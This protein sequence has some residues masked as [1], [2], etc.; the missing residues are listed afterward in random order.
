MISIIFSGGFRLGESWDECMVTAFI[1]TRETLTVVGCN[2]L[3]QYN[4]SIWRI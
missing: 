2:M 3:P 1:G 4:C